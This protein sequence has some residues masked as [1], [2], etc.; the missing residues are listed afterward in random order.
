MN[1]TIEEQFAKDDEV[2]RCPSE[3]T[4]GKSSICY[5]AHRCD[6]SEGH[7]GKHECDCGWKWT[8]GNG[9]AD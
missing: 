4:V 9:A 6:L 8:K 1:R 2:Y 3:K 5:P 7:E